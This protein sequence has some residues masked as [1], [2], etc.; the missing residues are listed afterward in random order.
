M[1]GIATL[2]IMHFTWNVAWVIC[3]VS[4]LASGI[5]ESGEF[6]R[7]TVSDTVVRPDRQQYTRRRTMM[8]ELE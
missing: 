1:V 2:P 3:D 5:T 7:D 4:C 8:R 6:R